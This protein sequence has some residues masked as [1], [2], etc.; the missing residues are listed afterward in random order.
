MGN[1]TMGN[2][3]TRDAAMVSQRNRGNILVESVVKIK[4]I[5]ASFVVP[6]ANP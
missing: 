3:A 5:V 2:T 6:K 4:T 1:K